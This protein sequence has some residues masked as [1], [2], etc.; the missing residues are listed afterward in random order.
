MSTSP[1]NAMIIFGSSRHVGN[2]AQATQAVQK[3]FPESEP[4]PIID[5]NDLS[6]G[7][8]D[9]EFKNQD[10]D[11]PILIDQL[12]KVDTIILASPVYWYS[13]SSIMKRFVERL[14]DLL[15]IHKDKGRQL[16]NKNL[17]VIASYSTS[18]EQFE[19][20]FIHT[21]HYLGMQ[22]L[23][24]YFHYAGTDEKLK[25]QNPEQCERF[26]KELEHAI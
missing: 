20:A 26:I 19:S 7:L 17:A 1:L 8:F 16:R 6:I 25:Q 11:F 10:D 18:V 4:I 14:S 5:L 2:T 22:Y 21:A 3:A 12:L 15:W 9:Y 13:M 23:G 24:C